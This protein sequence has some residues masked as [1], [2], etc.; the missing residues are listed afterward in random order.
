MIDYFN[1]VSQE[2]KT[3]YSPNN[4]VE[5]AQKLDVDGKYFLHW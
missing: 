2:Y 3:S 5:F 1:N 4:T